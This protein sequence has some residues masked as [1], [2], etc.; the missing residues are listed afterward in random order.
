MKVH[1]SQWNFEKQR[2]KRGATYEAIINKRLDKLALRVA[3]IF[4]DLVE[5]R[6][7]PTIELLRE[8]LKE[9]EEAVSAPAPVEVRSLIDFYEQFIEETKGRLRNGTTQVHQT[10]LNHVREFAKKH[11][12]N[13]TFERV[14][15]LFFEKFVNYL[16]KSAGQNNVTAWKVVRTFRVFLRW[17]VEEGLHNNNEYVRF[18]QKRMPKGEQ[19][20]KVYLTA[21]ELERLA[22]LDL[23]ANSR[24]D[25]VRDLFLFQCNTG[26]RYGDVSSLKPHHIK[27]DVIQLV[28]GKNRKAVAIPFMPKARAIWEKYNG[29]LPQISNQKQNDYLKE[30]CEV[31]GLDT[32]I[33]TVDYKGTERVEKVRPKYELIGTHTA[34]RSFVTILRQNGVSVE[35][36]MK[37][38]GNSRPTL[39]RYIL[40]TESDALQE[41]AAALK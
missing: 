5:A 11:A 20:D 16:I 29:S 28:T 35:A 34:K 15:L 3:T 36:I 1:P 22:T 4:M 39:E 12:M 23:T 37:V 7:P 25:R 9:K 31:A 18:T 19:S 40:R 13:L 32:P 21:Q 24:L 41:I 6:T 33:V 17:A 30:L 14:D 38:T 8:R 27:G 10:T 26:L 2:L